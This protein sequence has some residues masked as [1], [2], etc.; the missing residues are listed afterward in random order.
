[1]TASIQD[2]GT[3][4]DLLTLESREG[5]DTS[6]KAKERLLAATIM[7]SRT[8]LWKYKVML[9]LVSEQ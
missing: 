3:A 6:E 7:Q 4:L 9:E 5:A 2:S 8:S 1:M